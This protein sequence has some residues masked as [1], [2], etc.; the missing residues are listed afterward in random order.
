MR[1]NR[2]RIYH[3]RRWCYFGAEEVGNYSLGEDHSLGEVL[4]HSDRAYYHYYELPFLGE[5]RKIIEKIIAKF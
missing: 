1:D 5:A 3:Y 4:D 2:K